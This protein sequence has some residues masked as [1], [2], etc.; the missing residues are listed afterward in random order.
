MLFSININIIKE[1]KS[2]LTQTGGIVFVS[3]K[4]NLA[5]ISEKYGIV[6]SNPYLKNELPEQNMFY[7]ILFYLAVSRNNTTFV[8]LKNV[9]QVA[10]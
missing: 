6:G 8:M 1:N 10:R 5:A 2:K 3:R 7:N 9:G 4:H